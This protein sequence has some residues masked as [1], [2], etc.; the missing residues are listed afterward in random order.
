[1]IV[2]LSKA[3]WLFFL[4]GI[5]VLVGC[6]SQKENTDSVD[7]IIPGTGACQELL[8]DLAIAFNATE[9]E[10][11]VVI[12]D[13]IGSGGGIKLVQNNEAVLA[14]VA[15]P[16]RDAETKSGLRYFPFA[17]DAVVFAV[18]AK[19]ETRKLSVDQLSS[20][21]AGQKTFWTLENGHKQPIRV[22]KRQEGDSLIQ[23]LRQQLPQFSKLQLS[24]DA[25]VAYRDSEMVELLDK[26]IYS[27]GFISRAST[28]NQDRRFH[29]LS[30]ADFPLTN[31][32]LQSRSYPLVLDY[33]FVLKDNHSSEKIDLFMT[34]VRSSQGRSIIESSGMI[35][36]EE[37]S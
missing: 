11:K 17:R 22:L 15:R 1:M 6:F 14:R 35:A 25:K 7:L 3:Q 12:P 24:T 21:F 2:R 30:I 29:I 23:L 33:A 18:G 31:A 4:I 5:F 28:H 32:S 16:L 36:L 13:T 26:Y 37:G 34:F 27:I 19:V 9:Q 20:L 8:R 10:F